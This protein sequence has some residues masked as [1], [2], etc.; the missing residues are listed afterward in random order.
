MLKIM[1]VDDEPLLRMAVKSLLDWEASGFKML[2]EASDGE[3]AIEL[4][5]KEAPDILL[6][7]IKM[8]GMNGVELIKYI[9]NRYPQIKTVVLSNY[10]DFNFVKEALL[11]GA[12]DYILKATITPESLIHVINNLKEKLVKDERDEKENSKRE[13][14]IKK[15]FQRSKIE[16]LKNLISGSISSP[17]EIQFNNN[18]Y[19]AGLKDTKYIVCTLLADE[20]SGLAQKYKGEEKTI[21]QN[22]VMTILDEIS[23]FD[24]LFF[25]YN[26]NHYILIIYMDGFSENSFLSSVYE[27]LSRFQT[28]VFRYT[29]ISFTA[30]ISKIKGKLPEIHAAYRESV[31]AA[32][33]RFYMGAGKIFKYGDV[34]IKE[35]DP[36][37]K[38]RSKD[39]IKRIKDSV[40]RGNMDGINCI[41]KDCLEDIEQAHYHI[42]WVKQFLADFIVFL[43]ST[44]IEYI[45]DCEIDMTGG[46][47]VYSRFNECETYSE[48]KNLAFEEIKQM[49]QSLKKG[50]LEKYSDIVGKVIENIYANYDKSIT[51]H[52]IAEHINV[53]SSYLSR[54]FVQETGKNFIDYLTEFKVKKAMKLLEESN[55]SVHAIGEKIG[56]PNPKY[57]HRV[58]KRIAGVSPYQYR[59]KSKNQYI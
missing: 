15:N 44:L 48:M 20:W 56:Y 43:R 14:E 19:Q 22:T 3:S 49:G 38:W 51:L 35:E 30:G 10:D 50:R 32:V 8:P 33:Y 41:L 28:A 5:R 2:E 59:A 1:I 53:N 27:M 16:F 11:H 58:F 6:T 40:E 13:N 7:D 47:K 52:S 37:V 54:L 24:G 17:E 29:N 18:Y 4:I 25:A 34:A 46:E 12:V 39:N 55:L 21:L 26:L 45:E 57:F 9:E 23:K 31:Q 42:S 36:G